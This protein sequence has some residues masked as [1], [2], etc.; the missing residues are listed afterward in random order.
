MPGYKW[1]VERPY[2][3]KT[4]T[5]LGFAIMKATGIQSSGFIRMSTLEIVRR[6]EEDGAVNYEAKIAGYGTR[7]PWE[8]TCKRET[9][10]RA[11]RRLQD[12][13]VAMA[14]TYSACVRAMMAGRDA[15]KGGAE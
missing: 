10:A 15:A 12:H 8:A 4:D 11:M 14:A 6:R 7:G 1:T 3:F 13:C 9:L 5:A 2:R